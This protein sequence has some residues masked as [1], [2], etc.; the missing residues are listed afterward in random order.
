[1]LP[2]PLFRYTIL[3]GVL[4]GIGGLTYGL[5]VRYLGMSLGNSVVLGFCSA[6]GAIVPS[7]YYAIVP[8]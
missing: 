5:G 6:F 4:W 7:I 1:M 3:F 2:R 8:D